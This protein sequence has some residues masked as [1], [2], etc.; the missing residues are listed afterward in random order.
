MRRSVLARVMLDIWGEGDS[1]QEAV[2][3]VVASHGARPAA[4][5][6]R[7]RSRAPL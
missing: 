1:L 6:A 2:A 4:C 5:C 7:V 3:A